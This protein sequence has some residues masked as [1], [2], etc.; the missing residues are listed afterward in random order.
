[1]CTPDG[2][3]ED[4][5]AHASLSGGVRALTTRPA[6]RDARRLVGLLGVDGRP[7]RIEQAVV[8]V[9]LVQR[10]QRLER[11]RRVV[12]RGPRIAVAL[13]PLRQ[14]GQRQVVGV[15]VVE[16]LPADRRRDLPARRPL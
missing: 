14:I 7:R 6:R 12:D 3:N 10:Q 1:M 13:K 2:P 11:L 9:A 8:P 4:R 15:D 5:H 16:L